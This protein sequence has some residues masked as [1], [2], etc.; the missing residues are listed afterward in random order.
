M[1]TYI[2]LEKI[3]IYAYHGVAEQESCVG[4][5]YEVYVKVGYPIAAAMTSDHVAD[6][7]NYAELYDVINREMAIPSKL[8]EHVAGRIATS[9]RVQFPTITSLTLK[10]TKLRPPIVGEVAAASVIVSW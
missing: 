10:V 2:E 5:N 1:N 7:L 3:N 6:T 9:I 8:L 4:N